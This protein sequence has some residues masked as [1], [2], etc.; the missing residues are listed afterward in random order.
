MNHRSC[1]H[2]P[3]RQQGGPT[4]HT[5][6]P[7]V[8]TLA[9]HSERPWPTSGPSPAP[10]HPSNASLKPLTAL[11]QTLTIKSLLQKSGLSPT[12]HHHHPSNSPSKPLTAPFLIDPIPHWP[13]ACRQMCRCVDVHQGSGDD[14]LKSIL[15]HAG[16]YA[17]RC[18]SASRKQGFPACSKQQG[19]H[20]LHCTT[21][22]TAQRT[23]RHPP[24][25]CLTDTHHLVGPECERCAIMGDNN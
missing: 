8:N 9:A 13:C 2:G 24:T 21:Y 16:M 11:A 7:S 17:G 10:H 12:P 19:H 15:I 6:T 22:Y 5:Q 23:A 20:T 3:H 4:P 25:A 18:V 1:S 14:F